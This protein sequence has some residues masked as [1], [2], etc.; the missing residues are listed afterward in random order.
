MKK[1]PKERCPLCGKYLKYQ[2]IHKTHYDYNTSRW[3]PT[4]IK[5]QGDKRKFHYV[6]DPQKQTSTMIIMPYS[7]IT[8]K[9]NSFIYSY[10]S[11]DLKRKLFNF[12]LETPP[13]Q[14]MEQSKLL[15]KIKMII[16][17]S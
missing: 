1:P 10:D 4:V 6:Y 16:L 13:I 8:N 17:F 12:I 2:Q 3:C 15:Q 5:L 14:P 7:I 9:Y 11:N